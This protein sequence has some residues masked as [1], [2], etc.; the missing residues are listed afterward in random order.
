MSKNSE[1]DDGNEEEKDD[2]EPDDDLSN[3]PGLRS[4][5]TSTVQSV[6]YLEWT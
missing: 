4:F 1:N 2:D 6:I 3:V 5:V